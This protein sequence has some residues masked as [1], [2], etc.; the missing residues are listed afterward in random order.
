[1]RKRVVL[2]G[3]A[4]SLICAGIARTESIA[5]VSFNA[6][7]VAKR[8][9]ATTT[10]DLDLALSS[11]VAPSTT[12][13]LIDRSLRTT[14][15]YLHFGLSHPTSLKFDNQERE[16]NCIEYAN[17]FALVFDRMAARANS[18]AR[19]YAVHST[20]ARFLGQIVPGR[21]M[22]EHDWVLVVE[23]NTTGDKRYYIDPTFYDMGLP[24][25][26]TSSV[27]GTVTPPR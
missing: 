18:T 11:D 5:T 12:P 16:G 3:V 1:M 7:H 27:H 20:D 21:G 19:A 9:A 10:H 23:P 8:S 14:G 22:G 26:I 13:L 24:W 4:I 15:S 2:A 17:L 6:P 25:D